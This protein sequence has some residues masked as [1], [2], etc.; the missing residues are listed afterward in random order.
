MRVSSPKCEVRIF[1]TFGRWIAVA[2][3]CGRVLTKSGDVVG[4][5][6]TCRGLSGEKVQES[7]ERVEFARPLSV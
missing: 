7:G 2:K 6:W 5:A 3:G 4:S 1:W